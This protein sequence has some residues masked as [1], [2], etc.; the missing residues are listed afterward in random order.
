MSGRASSSPL[1]SVLLAARNAGA[2][3]GAS[4]ESLLA[5]TERSFEL[6]LV[7][8]GSTDATAILA[9]RYA[10]LDARVRVLSR[11]HRGLTA[12]LDEACGLARGEFI[13][14]QDVDD[15]SAPERLRAQLDLL[16]SERDAVAATCWTEFV[17]PLGETVIHYQP[18]AAEVAE[19][20][21]R[22]DPRLLSNPPHPTL[23][24][25]RC[26]FTAAGGYR[27]AFTRAQDVD[28]WLRLV[29]QGRIGVV[30]RYLYRVQLS[31]GSVS[32]L[33]SSEQDELRVLAVECALARRQG[34]SEA[35]ILAAAAAVR[36]RLPTERERQRR[37]AAANYFYA[38]CLASAA[39]ARARAYCLRALA[40]DPLHLRAWVRMLGT[41]L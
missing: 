25:R 41:C 24:V 30:T 5:Q 10:R 7:D 26:A 35:P 14:R 37:T 12:S 17:A 11:P 20:L 32:S 18:S 38:A 29:E 27:T 21:S 33:H 40:A 19:G 15:T 9:A 4:V 23:L 28:L 36:P 8:D 2:T 1:V 31:T 39:P 6:L 3:L 13:A 34:R 16:E 22:L